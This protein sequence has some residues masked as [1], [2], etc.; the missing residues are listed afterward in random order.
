MKERKSYSL[1]DASSDLHSPVARRLAPAMTRPLRVLLIDDSSVD[2][3]LA[4][5]AFAL[6]DP[7]AVLVTA[8][9][10]A[11]ALR[12]L[13]AP[14][15]VLPDLV[16]LDL[17]MPGMNGFAVLEQLKRHPT[18]Q[19]LP[20]LMLTTSRADDDIQQA[21]ALHASA[22]L[23]KAISFEGFLAQLEALLTFWTRAK[24]TTWPLPLGQEG[25]R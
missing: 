4:E 22:Y 5:E 10:G 8:P 20:V 25:V 15:A 16:L 12:D 13:T 3:A 17:N 6:L 1:C 24:T 9:G 18:L 14:E 21:Y 11:E 7:P 19:S 2:R 23:P